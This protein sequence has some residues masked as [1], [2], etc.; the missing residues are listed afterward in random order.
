MTQIYDPFTIRYRNPRLERT[1]YR[2]FFVSDNICAQYH[3]SLPEDRA[4]NLFIKHL[5]P[6]QLLTF[7]ENS[8]IDVKSN[9]GHKYR[10]DTNKLCINITR[11]GFFIIRRKFCIILKNF[12]IPRYDHFLAQKIL[13]ESDESQFLKIANKYR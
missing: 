2:N 10:I 6:S 9:R 5:S 11:L 4:K 7:K 8:Y 13:I 12:M 1:D 3:Y